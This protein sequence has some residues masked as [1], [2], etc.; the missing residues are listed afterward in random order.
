MRRAPS[1]RHPLAVGRSGTSA[2]AGRAAARRHRFSVA[3]VAVLATLFAVL[4]F[5]Q[6]AAAQGRMAPPNESCD[7]VAVVAKLSVVEDQAAAN[8]LAEAM[9]ILGLG[10]RCLVDAGDWKTGLLPPGGYGGL[11][12]TD[13]VYVVGGADA[14]P[15]WW[16]SNALGVGGH[17]RIAGGNRWDTQTAVAAAIVSLARGEPI[18]AYS[19]QSPS[20]SEPPPN[21]GCT[22]AVVA[23]LSVVEDRAAANMLAEVF[24]QLSAN[25]DDRCLLDVGDPRTNTVPTAGAVE[26]FGGAD[27]RYVIGGSAAIPNAWINEHFS[28]RGYQPYLR[29]AGADRWATQSAVTSRIIHLA[30]PSQAEDVTLMRQSARPLS[31]VSLSLAAT[32]RET[33]LTLPVYYCGAE[34]NYTTEQLD[35]R[36]QEL[37]AVAAF[38]RRQSGD[39]INI[40]FARGTTD[41]G[42]LTAAAVAQH[43]NI[44]DW[45]EAAPTTVHDECLQDASVDEPGI[46]LLIGD[47]PGGGYAYLPED[48][49]RYGGPAVVSTPQQ[50]SGGLQ[51]FLYVTAH[52]IAH[53]FYGLRHPWMDYPYLCKKILEIEEADDIAGTSLSDDEW[54]HCQQPHSD[55]ETLSQKESNHLLGSIASYLRY[56]ASQDLGSGGAYVACYQRA[57]GYLGWVEP[58]ECEQYRA[59]VPGQPLPPIVNAGTNSLSVEWGVPSLNGAEIIDYDLQIK[60]AGSDYWDA[61]AHDGIARRAEVGGLETGTLYSIRVRASNRIGPSPWSTPTEA[62]TLDGGRGPETRRVYLSRGDRVQGDSRCTHESCH[63]LHVEIDGFPDGSYTLACAHNGVHQ[64]G[65]HRGVYRSAAAAVSSDRPS[66]RDCFFGYPGNEVFVI[67]GAEK[68][69]DAWHGGTYSNIVE[70]ETPPPVPPQSGAMINDNPQLIDRIGNYT[71]L[72]PPAEVNAGGYGNNGFHFTVAIGNSGDNETDNIARWD[73]PAVGGYFELEA[74]IPAAWSTAHVQY[75][76][77]VDNNNDGDFIDSGEYFTDAWLDQ[78]QYTTGG[79]RTLGSYIFTVSRRIRIEVSDT[80]ARDDH[81]DVGIV[82]ARI[83]VDAIRLTPT[84]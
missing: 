82:N 18:V 10:G 19:S 20:W 36:I 35:Q 68:H 21:T 22:N 83:A 17:E 64:I 72:V 4:A 47:A 61:V 48:P 15:A 54:Q 75:R 52:E 67:V 81:R 25:G 62:T 40:V 24:N 33:T 31:D 70:W 79:W 74:W 42:I 41:N 55:A 14:I 73:F 2:A 16:L 43:A 46:V 45:Y 51:T 3:T 26:A 5:P 11:A 60:R 76:I 57:Q 49:R 71:W 30:V 44:Q 39:R 65:A 27:S 7:R 32:I 59:A 34:A 77:Y 12:G 23:K 56:G 63:W 69:D 58:D 9:R 78:G 37:S 50:L 8:M 29:L 28:Y 80:G 1:P 84:P 13:R 38:F 6:P 66:T 53:A